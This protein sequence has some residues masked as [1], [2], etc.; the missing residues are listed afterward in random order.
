MEE[1]SKGGSQ[2]AVPFGGALKAPAPVSPVADESLDVGGEAHWSVNLSSSNQWLDNAH[3]VATWYAGKEP[4]AGGALQ[5]FPAPALRRVTREETLRYFENCWALGETLFAGLKGEEAWFKPVDHGLR[6]P[7]IFYY[8]HN[9]C[10]YVNKLRD[11]GLID[12]P[13][14]EHYE[15][16]FAMGVDEF[17][18]NDMN[19]NHKKWPSVE[20]VLAYRKEVHR[21]VSDVIKTHPLLESPEG[22]PVDSKSPLWSLFMTFEHELIHLELSSVLICEAPIHLAQVPVGWPALHPSAQRSPRVR[23]SP[24]EGVDFPR[25]VPLPVPGAVVEIGKPD[26]FPSYGWDNEWGSRTV[27]VAEFK[28]SPHLVTNGEF[29]HF[30]KAGGYNTSRFWSDDSWGWRTFRSRQWPM[31]WL[32]DGPAESLEF[33]V[34]T[35]FE[36]KEMQWDWPVIVNF[37]EAKAFCAWKSEQDGLNDSAEAYRL[38]TEAEHHAIRGDMAPLE[39]QGKTVSHDR[40]MQV[41]GEGFA[42]GSRGAN[43]NLAFGSLSP[44]DAMPPSSTGHFD[45]LGNAWE[46]TEDHFNTLDGFETHFLYPEYSV[47]SVDG[48]HQLIMGGSFIS[49]GTGASLFVRTHFRPHFFQ[50]TG[51]RLVSSKA[52]PPAT[53]VTPDRVI[54][55]PP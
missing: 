28:A 32:P 33:K 55:P 14:N 40:I 13:V 38:I 24:E 5:P 45:V 48:L 11:A 47:Q 21:V 4:P 34:R 23:T 42:Q 20:E 30:V 12:G 41:G 26:D 46:W 25:N 27:Q 44:V 50:H 17:S 53:K 8:G 1:V 29:W 16:L 15:T 43:L 51:F 9:A 31:F 18:W 37:H 10:F 22:V 2:G 3:K 35:L 52:P 54:V 36:L 49:T 39:R 7:Q 19:K 6:H